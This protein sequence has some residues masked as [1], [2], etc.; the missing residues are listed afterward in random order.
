MVHLVWVGVSTDCMGQNL[1][2]LSPFMYS[3]SGSSNHLLSC[4]LHTV[5]FDY[6]YVGG[7]LTNVNI[8]SDWYTACA[9]FLVS[10]I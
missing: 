5:D 10:V 4:D 2:I 9:G 1:E 3:T 6:D 7:P 8:K